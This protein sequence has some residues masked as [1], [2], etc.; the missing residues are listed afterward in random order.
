MGKYRPKKLIKRELK[1]ILAT[2]TSCSSIAEIPKG[3]ATLGKGEG[4]KLWNIEWTVLKFIPTEFT[5]FCNIVFCGALL[6]PG[7]DGKIMLMN[8]DGEVQSVMIP[9]SKKHGEVMCMKYSTALD[10]I[11]SCYESGLVVVWQKDGVPLCDT[12][13]EDT[14]MCLDISDNF[15]KVLIGTSGMYLHKLSFKNGALTFESKTEITN[16]DTLESIHKENPDILIKFVRLVLKT[17]DNSWNFRD[18]YAQTED[19]GGQISTPEDST[20][21]EVGG[22]V[23]EDKEPE[24]VWDLK[25]L[26][27]DVRSVAEQTLNQ[28]SFVFDSR[29]GSYYNHE[30]QC[31]YVPDYKLYYYVQNKAYYSYDEENNCMKFYSSADTPQYQDSSGAGGESNERGDTAVSNTLSSP[32]PSLIESPASPKCSKTEEPKKPIRSLDDEI[33]EGEIVDDDEDSA[34]YPASPQQA[35]SATPPV[36]SASPTRKDL[37]VEPEDHCAPCVRITVREC[38]DGL[39]IGQLFIITRSG[40]TLGREGKHD[41]IIPDTNVSKNHL[42]F[43]YKYREGMDVYEIVD[44]SK[45]GTFLDGGCMVQNQLYQLQHGSVLKVGDTSLLCHIHE[46]TGTC[47]ECEPGCLGFMNPVSPPPPPSGSSL[48]ARHAL[49]MA[50][51]KRKFGLNKY[52]ARELPKGYEDKSKIRR[53][54]VG[55]S[56]DS[57]KTDAT[58]MEAPIRSGN[59]GYEMLTKMGWKEGKAVGK[60]GE[61]STS[62]VNVTLKFSKRGL[63]CSEDDYVPPM[64]PKSKT[65][66][67]EITKKRYET[68]E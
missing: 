45:N 1:K 23:E 47:Y 30:Q 17:F 55:S 29:S 44:S 63:G 27:E 56:H 61:G 54:T 59:K 50:Q 48:K 42:S 68:C 19:L 33:E 34:S 22:N 52:T 18:G 64:K 67:L 36:I 43:H 65:K 13:V 60:S 49:E 41:I 25:S 14:P 24:Q 11:V 12:E 37:N 39:E 32:G 28:S 7:S 9:D 20:G 35:Y 38:G 2:E 6:L 10:V 53:E 31:Y 40:G 16:P 58:S 51:I 5:G 66:N 62:P 3:Y 46:G 4:V 15:S 8:L 21:A 26:A 57:E